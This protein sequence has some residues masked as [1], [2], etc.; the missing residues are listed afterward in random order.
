MSQITAVGCGREGHA[1]QGRAQGGRVVPLTSTQWKFE[2]LPLGCKGFQFLDL[3]GLAVGLVLVVVHQDHEVV[4]AALACAHGRFPD[5]ALVAFAV[6]KDREHAML[7]AADAGVQGHAKAHGE[8]VAQGPGGDLHAR[9]IVGAGVS[10][11]E[12]VQAQNSARRSRGKKPLS[13]RSTYWARQP[14]PLLR[15][16]RS[17]SAQ[18]G[19][20]GSKRRCRRRAPAGS[21]T[22]TGTSTQMAAA[23]AGEHVHDH[24]P[25]GPGALVHGACDER[26]AGGGQSPSRHV[27][28][29]GARYLTLRA[30]MR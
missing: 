1:A 7:A 25:Q 10:A 16:Q 18:S 5:R 14:W 24:E 11:Q 17:R 12:P 23:R 27:L 8:P 15:M 6:A 13:A 30:C 19:R 4:Q 2:G 9:D 22:R 20:A 28:R 29:F 21:P 26:R 3:A